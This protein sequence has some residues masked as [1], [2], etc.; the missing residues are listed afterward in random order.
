MTE[1]S[2]AD[3]CACLERGPI[4]PHREVSSLGTDETEGRFADVELSRCTHCGRLWLS[5]QVE[6]ESFSRSGRWAMGLIDAATAARM[7]PEQAAE[8][9]HG[10]DWYIYGGSLFGHGGKRGCGP[11]RWG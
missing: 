9:L 3:A 10:L 4:S 2:Q 1:T 8:Y 5:Y 7:T 6:Y 11:M